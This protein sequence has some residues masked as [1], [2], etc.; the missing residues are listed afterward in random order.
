[1][2]RQLIYT[3]VRQAV[4]DEAEV[5]RGTDIT[6]YNFRNIGSELLHDA[7]RRWLENHF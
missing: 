5:A 3:S 6:F 1:M 4:D 2:Q 7:R